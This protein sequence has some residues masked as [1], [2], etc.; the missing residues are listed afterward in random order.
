MHRPIHRNYNKKNTWLNTLNIKFSLDI[1]VLIFGLPGRGRGVGLVPERTWLACF[2]QFYGDFS[3]KSSFSVFVSILFYS[4]VTQT[5][6]C[7][8]EIDQLHY[9]I[10][11]FCRPI[12]IGR[13]KS[14]DFWCHTDDFCR[15]MSSADKIG[16]F[17]SFVRPLLNNYRVGWVGQSNFAG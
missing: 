9:F 15:P 13:Q 1:I 16:R 8:I 14:A 3:F 6:I 7:L 4:R 17:L 2:A 5:R 11:R 10:G 12:F